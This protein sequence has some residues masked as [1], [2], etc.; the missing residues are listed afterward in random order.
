MLETTLA[1]QIAR[2][3]E[4]W[5]GFQTEDLSELSAVGSLVAKVIFLSDFATNGATPDQAVESGEGDAS[6]SKGVF[7]SSS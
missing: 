6:P 7:T 5:R 2:N 3:T 4:L 1:I